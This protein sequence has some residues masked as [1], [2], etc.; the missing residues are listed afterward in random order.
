MDFRLLGRLEATRDG[1]P[2][3]LGRR[4]ERCLL[5][6]LLLEANSPITI[7][8]LV[9]LLWE[10][11]PPSTARSSL[12]THVSRLRAQLDPDGTGRYG[13]RLVS[14]GGG[15]AVEVAPDSV[16][17]HRFQAMVERARI[18]SPADRTGL[19]RQ[20]LA[21]WR[22]PV[23]A[24][25]ASDRL[26]ERIAA[27]LT[28]LRMSATELMI[29]TELAAD[30]P[31]D[32]VGELAGLH[33]EHPYRERLAGQLM[34]ALYRAGRH[35]DA[36]IVYQQLA[37]R[38][39]EDLGVDPGPEL[40]ELHTAIL[41]RDPGLIRSRPA[42]QT[43]RQLPAASRL[44]TGRADELG[45]LTKTLTGVTDRDTTVVVSAI[46][47]AGKTWL[48]LH[49]AHQNLDRFPDG[50][51]FVNLR[52]FDPSGQPMAPATA[53][54]GL[55]DALGVAPSAVPTDLDAQIGLYRSLLATRRMLIVLDNA[56]DASQVAPLLPGSP[57]CTVIVTSRDR[58]TGLINGYGALPL[59]LDILDEAQARDLL[60][61]RLGEERLAGEPEAV[62]ALVN[63]CGGLPLALGVVASRA[64]LAPHLPLA[65][66]TAE[67]HDAT[68]R[69]GAFDEDDPQAS[70]RAVLSWSYAALTGAQARLFG[71]LGSAAGPDIGLPAATA[72]AGLPTDE[73]TAILRALQR[74]SLIQQHSPGRWRMHD[75]IRLYAA[76]RAER[77]Q[78]EDHVAGLRRL[79]GFYLNTAHAADRLL[80]PTRPGHGWA[81]VDPAPGIPAHPLPDRAAAQAWLDDEHLC[82]QAA[83]QLAARQG[84]HAETWQLAWSLN[85]FYGWRGHLHD[86][87]T[88]WR[89]G[90]A[91]AQLLGDPAVEA[92]AHRYL[93]RAC[94]LVGQHV[95]AADQLHRS[96]SLAEQAADLPG[97]A[98]AHWTLAWASE[99]RGDNERALEHATRALELYRACGDP[100]GEGG[101]LNVVGWYATR[102]GHYDQAR[103]HLES[104]LIVSRDTGNRVGEADTLDSLGLVAHHTGQYAEAIDHYQ[105][106]LAVYR[107]LGNEYEEA[108]TLERLGETYA[109]TGERGPARRAWR[110]ALRLLRAQRRSPD[111]ERVERRLRH[112]GGSGGSG[113][114]P[115]VPGRRAGPSRQ[116]PD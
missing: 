77:D 115:T 61:R 79:V 7:D 8:R 87:V 95:E 82:V 116:R 46:G 108:D 50:Q 63:G 78:P 75:L 80:D 86:L 37:D 15:Y 52:G 34:L 112:V 42:A 62:T 98:R 103:T 57:T 44:F 84:W 60:A 27:E 47:G 106:A 110:E 73:V 64:A 38:L 92:L 11:Q 29:E 69:L 114:S 25:V 35:A 17:A 113:G 13:V 26:R 56:R 2:V 96:L 5:G 4:R 72:L 19:L 105:K 28:E 99:W 66:I 89:C 97:Q 32:L 109:A 48:A 93:G 41:R 70:L 91:A 67:L 100:V 43:P 6:V 9:D 65:A 58:L 85:T 74:Q 21:L 12:H 31:R 49:W 59:Q 18:V 51:L 22:G 88:V 16:D 104:A 54:H 55:L 24:D 3:E 71:L 30:R 40:S 83:Q 36:L 14:R 102:L 111:A 45:A 10:G 107:D 94:I 68:T 39:A 81:V 20:A 33:A 1:R 23:L 53:L 76:E 90:L 101:A